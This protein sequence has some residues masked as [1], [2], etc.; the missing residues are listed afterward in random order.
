MFK[1]KNKDTR[2]M[3]GVVSGVFSVNFEHVIKPLTTVAKLS[4]ASFWSLYFTPCSCV[5]IVNFEQVIAGCG[6]KRGLTSP[7]QI[8][9][10]Q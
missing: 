9:S 2:T 5:S 1:V 3:P 8:R 6:M 7:F 4:I 10:L